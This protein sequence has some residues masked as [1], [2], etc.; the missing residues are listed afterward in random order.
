MLWGIPCA[1]LAKAGWVYPTGST[2][3]VAEIVP[4]KYVVLSAASEDLPFN[5]V[6]SFHLQPHWEDRVR[7]LT[8]ARIALRHPGE[9]FALE[10]ARPVIALGTRGIV[11]WNQAPGRATAHDGCRTAAPG[12]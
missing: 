4:E 6:W 10:L 11:A 12:C 9:V 8:R 1:W 2:L 3:S 5:A 7:V